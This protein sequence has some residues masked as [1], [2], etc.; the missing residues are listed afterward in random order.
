LIQSASVD[1]DYFDWL[2]GLVWPTRVKNPARSNRL[3][4]EQLHTKPFRWFIHNDDNRGLDGVE[5][6]S[7]FLSVYPN[8]RPT[9]E[10]MDLDCSILEMLIALARRTAYESSGTTDEWA[11]QLLDNLGIRRFT[12]DTYHEGI[13]QE[14]DE[15][16]EQLL[17]R[18]YSPDGVGG[19]FPLR[20]ADLDQRRVELWHQ[21]STYVLEGDAVANGP[22]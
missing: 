7:E 20:Y 17:N 8:V 10:W 5:L 6:R 3:L 19:L 15:V 12:D 4:A 16:L 9:Q 2:Y 21:M 22:Y 11:A 13:R 14:V 1:E 18:T